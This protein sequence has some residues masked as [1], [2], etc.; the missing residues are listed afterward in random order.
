VSF[1]EI[2]GD[3]ISEEISKYEFQRQFEFKLCYVSAD[4]TMTWEQGKNRIVYDLPQKPRVEIRFGFG[5]EDMV[6]E[7]KG[8]K[9]DEYLFSKGAASQSKLKGVSKV[10]SQKK[11]MSNII[12]SKAKLVSIYLELKE[13]IAQDDK[14]NK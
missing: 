8:D 14:M 5:S 3:Y 10:E 2:D 1:N 13:E 12:D 9:L 7:G 4:Q 6:I 11:Q